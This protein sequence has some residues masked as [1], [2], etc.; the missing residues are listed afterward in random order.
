MN[1]DTTQ[2]EKFKVHGTARRASWREFETGSQG[3]E[4]LFDL[5]APLPGT[6]EMVASGVLWTT[7]KSTE[8]TGRV[9]RA[10]G[11][12]LDGPGLTNN[13]LL[14]QIEGKD[15]S[16]SFVLEPPN[17]YHKRDQWKVAW[18]NGVEREAQGDLV[19]LL[20]G[21]PAAPLRQ[22]DEVPF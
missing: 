12:D 15:F 4:I 2:S 16:L 3:I 9:L 14:K 7:P 11:I 19:G 18:I 5:E 13:A 22:D 6:G 20:G 10:V 17:Q 1:D 21:H 8:N